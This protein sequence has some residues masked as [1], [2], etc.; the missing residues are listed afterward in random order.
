LGGKKK[1]P[2]DMD[3][4]RHEMG[5]VR[6]LKFEKR[7]PSKPPRADGKHEPQIRSLSESVKEGLRPSQRCP[8]FPDKKM[9]KT[10][11]E[12]INAAHYVKQ[13]WQN[14]VRPY[15]CFYCHQYHLTSK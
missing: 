10:L 9:Y 13:E 2:E 12:A 1:T 8:E 3:L 6:P 14:T 15:H 11:E 5:D 4:F 7:V